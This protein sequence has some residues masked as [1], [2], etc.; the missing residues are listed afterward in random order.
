MCIPRDGRVKLAYAFGC[1]DHHQRDVGVFQM[2]ARHHH[3]EFFRHQVGL[4]FSPDAC[5]IDKPETTSVALDQFVHCIAGGAGDWGN[6]RS[7][8]SRQPVQQSRLSHV[9]MSD[10]GDLYFPI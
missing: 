2:L 10:D 4:P 5:G 1:V 3:G 7:I 6:N 8:G 9:W